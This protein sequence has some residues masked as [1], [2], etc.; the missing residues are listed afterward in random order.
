MLILGRRLDETVVITSPDG[1]RIVLRVI[2][3]RA[4]HTV[5]LGFDAPM[6]FVIHRGEIQDAIDREKQ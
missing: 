4:G 1:T 2:E 3:I 5:R 6:D